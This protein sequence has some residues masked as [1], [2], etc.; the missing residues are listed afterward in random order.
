LRVL[1]AVLERRVVG[2]MTMKWLFSSPDVRRHDATGR[3]SVTRGD[4]PV[5]AAE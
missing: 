5:Y 1:D 4:S 3:R 2:I